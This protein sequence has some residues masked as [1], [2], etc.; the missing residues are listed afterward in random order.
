[1]AELAV[2]YPALARMLRT[3]AKMCHVMTWPHPT[4]WMRARAAASDQTYN[5]KEHVSDSEDER[6]ERG[7]Q[8]KYPEYVSWQGILALCL[9]TRMARRSFRHWVWWLVEVKSAA[10]YNS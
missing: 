10:F 8:R 5:E 6:D 2:T 1:M 3:Q 4:S 9:A 7:V